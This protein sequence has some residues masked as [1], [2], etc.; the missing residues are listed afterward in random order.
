M[1]R[2]REITITLLAKGRICYAVILNANFCTKKYQYCH[3][4]RAETVKLEPKIDRR[5]KISAEY[6]NDQ[7]I[8]RTVRFRPLRSFNEPI[9]SRKRGCSRPR[10]SGHV[11]KVQIPG[12]GVW[13]R[14]RSAA[15]WSTRQHID[16]IDLIKLNRINLTALF[17][18]WVC[19]MRTRKFTDYLI[20]RNLTQR[21]LI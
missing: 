7:K 4:T 9:L 18:R 15:S 20:I 1:L 6:A 13:L 16:L 12:A 2:G 8:D 5:I 3:H 14:R 21:N 10:Q 17:C 11:V 19:S